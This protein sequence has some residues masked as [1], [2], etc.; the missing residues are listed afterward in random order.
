MTPGAVGRWLASA[1]V[2]TPPATGEPLLRSARRP[3]AAVGAALLAA[4]LL[5][6]AAAADDPPSLSHQEVPSDLDLDG[7]TYEPRSLEAAESSDV[8]RPAEASSSGQYL[9]ELSGEPVAV[10]EGQAR[11]RGQE[12]AAERR[13]SIANELRAAQ[14]PAARAIEARGARVERDFQ[15]AVNGF[16]VTADLHIAR[17]LAELPEVV[18]VHSIELM[19]TTHGDSLP[20]LEIPEVWERVEATGEGISVGVIDT[21]IDYTHAMFGGEGTT[22]AY[23]EE[24]ANE[25]FEPTAR[26][27]GGEDFV[28]NDYDASDP[29]ND[30]PNPTGD[31]IDCNGHGTHVAGTVGGNGVTADGATYDGAYDA[32]TLTDFDLAISPGVAPHVD[33][34][35]LKVFGCEGSTAVTVDAIEWAVEEE[36]DVINMSLGS[37]AGTPDNPSV[38]ASENAAEAGVLVIAS[39]GNS[40]DVPYITGAPGAS[41]RTISV[42]ANDAAA[43]FPGAELLLD[44]EQTITAMVGNGAEVEAGTEWDVH[45]LGGAD[46]PALGCAEDPAWEEEADEIAGNLVVTIRGECALVER[47][48]AAQEAGAAGVLMVN[49]VDGL[50]PFVGPIPGVDIPFLYT[51]GEDAPAAVAAEVIAV[52]GTAELDNPGFTGLAPFTSSGPRNTDGALK[53]DVT[54]PGVSVLSAGVGS[55]T[56]GLVLS[57][58]SMAAPHVAGVAAIAKQVHDDWDVEDLR[59]VITSTS[60]PDAIGGN[61]PFNVR[62]AGAGMVQPN[63]IVDATTVAHGDE[64]T[65]TVSFGILEVTGTTTVTGEIEVRN[66]GEAPVTYSATAADAAR[67]ATH[68]VSLSDE[69]VTVGAGESATVEV[70][71]DIDATALDAGALGVDFLDVSGTVRFLPID[72]E[73]AALTVPYLGV[74]VP[75]AELDI[76][77]TD[78]DDLLV[79]NTG[80]RLATIHPFALGALGDDNGRAVD[81]Q[82]VGARTDVFAAPDGELPTVEFGVS[83]HRPWSQAATT[84]VEIP[85]DTSGDG[86][87]DVI[88]LGIDIGLL[89]GLGLT[90]DVV[91]AVLDLESGALTANFLA[92]APEDNHTMVLPVLEADLGLGEDR[93]FGYGGFVLAEDLLTGDVDLIEGA[94]SSFDAGAPEVDGPVAV[95]LPGTTERIAV[96]TTLRPRGRFLVLSPQASVGAQAEIVEVRGRRGPPEDRGPGDDRPGRGGPPDGRGGGRG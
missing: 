3:L 96:E 79:A 47:P 39:A 14:Q 88:V 75:R 56:G 30:V 17:E 15:Y 37:V 73:A 46:G 67:S 43:T 7:A 66:L 65:S 58:T 76:S 95:S 38:I 71:V 42:A 22:D 85:V 63:T 45:V 49:N 57:G 41:T 86:A 34:Y 61:A 16:R 94:Q 83:L 90:G 4:A 91:A 23:E 8:P 72:G 5:P 27:V 52:E 18:G 26:I 84:V 6:V 20:L 31:P 59:A 60:D 29:D 62:Q 89:L 70:F 80:E 40:G 2:H 13:A 53:P 24:F 50:P 11:N 9:V 1:G 44:G 32:D 55:G 51:T 81:L 48:I 82:A 68:D 35:A 64:G 25:T 54:A 74:A 12:I 87:P 78:V 28:G 93:T 21:G 92:F 19:E 10:Q 69:Q 77:T 36:L 33:L